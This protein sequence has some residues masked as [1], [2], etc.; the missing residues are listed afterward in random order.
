[1]RSLGIFVVFFSTVMSLGVEPVNAQVYP[2]GFAQVL[3]T[4][5]ISNPTVMAFAPDGRIFVAQQGGSLRVIKNNA[6]LPTPFISLTVNSSGERG[7]IGIAL[8]PDFTTNNYIYLYYTVS[9][10]PIHNRVSRFTANGDVVLAGSEAII[11][12]LDA[13]SGATNHN[14]G[15]MH[16]GK[17]GKLYIAIGENANTAHAQNL[18]TYHGKLLAYK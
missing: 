5:G 6:L 15:A 8:D 13:L 18:D 1:M 7:L 17:D 4:N 14:G 16:F 12:E 10:A 2:T 11:L 9:V 3:V